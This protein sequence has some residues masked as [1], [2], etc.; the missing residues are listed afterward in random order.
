MNALFIGRFQPFHKGHL[1]ILQSISNQ[2][3]EIIIG[4]GSSQYSGTIV[5]P[6]SENERKKMIAKSLDDIGINNYKIVL[7]PDIHNPPKWVSHVLSI[8]RNFDV[9]VSNNSFTKQ[10]FSE[11]GYFV[12]RTP[13]FEKERYSGEEIRRRMINN[14]K[15]EDLVPK[16]VAKI[17]KEI[18]G[19]QR[20]KDLSR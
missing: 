10:L 17:I 19:V 6:F 11:K 13:Y 3:D 14:E 12:K 20:L 15:W 5:N 16:S 9:V 2:Y 7:I 18:N 8:V 1:I 4:I